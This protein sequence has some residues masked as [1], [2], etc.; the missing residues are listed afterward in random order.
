MTK[1]LSLINPIIEWANE[2]NL[3]ISAKAWNDLRSRLGQSSAP[4]ACEADERRGLYGKYR[5][6]RTNGSSGPGG[7]H[8]RCEY[9]VLDLAHDKYAFDALQAYALACREEFPQL[10]SDLLRRSVGERSDELARTENAR[11]AV[12]SSGADDT[13]RTQ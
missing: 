11:R 4:N 1:T 8:E 9:F 10:A 6:E 5:V 7:K 2:H 12:P 3:D 13:E